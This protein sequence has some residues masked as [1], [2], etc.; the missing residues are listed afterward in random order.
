MKIKWYA[1]CCVALLSPLAMAAE[2]GGTIQF[3]G[4]VVSGACAVHSDSAMQT[5]N[6]GQ[7]RKAALDTA[8]GNVSGSTAFKIMLADCDSDVA[9][10]ASASFGGVATDP[11]MQILSL[12]EGPNNAKGV[13]LRIEDHQSNLVTFDGVTK[14][15]TK[16]LGA[17]DNQLQ[18]NAHYVSTATGAALKAGDASATVDFNVNYF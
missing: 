11:K 8:M 14:T 10:N 17:S 2:N 1:A 12:G 15:A 18:F 5:V 6:M 9:G 13:G 3:K 16:A 7:V 4:S